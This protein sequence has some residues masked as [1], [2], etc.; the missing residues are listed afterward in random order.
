VGRYDG[1]NPRKRLAAHPYFTQSGKDREDSP[2]QYIA[3]MRNGSVA[4]FKYFDCKGIQTISIEL[5]GV[6]NGR[7]I[8]SITPNFQTMNASIPVNLKG[9]YA[10]FSAPCL[11]PNGVWPLYF[12]FQG[13]G[14]TDFHFFSLKGDAE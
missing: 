9:E 13:T 7:F 5:G 12:K 11:L 14:H 10:E 1:P 4:G 3:N 8:L 2:D 6:A